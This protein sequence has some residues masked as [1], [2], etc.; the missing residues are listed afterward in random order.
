M[1]HPTAGVRN[2]RHH[3]PVSQQRIVRSGPLPFEAGPQQ[4]DAACSQAGL[5]IA[6]GESLVDDQQQAGPVGCRLRLPDRHRRQHLALID[7]RAGQ[8]PGDRHARRGA[9]QEQP[10][11]SGCGA[12]AEH[13]LGHCQADQLRAAEQR[14]SADA[15]GSSELVDAGQPIPFRIGGPFDVAQ[16]IEEHGIDDVDTYFKSPLPDGAGWMSGGG[17]GMGN[18]GYLARL[19]LMNPALV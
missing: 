8:G 15:P 5:E 7:L 16:A 17:G 10:Q 18:I 1:T 9:D 4:L 3:R 12:E 14:R 13:G 19:D 11:P 6:G 2:A